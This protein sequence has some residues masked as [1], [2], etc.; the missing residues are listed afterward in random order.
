VVMVIISVI[1]LIIVA[2]LVST[3]RGSNKTANLNEVRENGNGA[4]TRMAEAISFAKSFEGLTNTPDTNSIP[5]VPTSDIYTCPAPKDTPDHFT[6]LYLKDFSDN[7][8]V[9]SCVNSDS[10]GSTS[11]LWN[12]T[13]LIDTHS[14]SID[15]SDPN[16]CYFTCSQ[17]YSTQ[18]P[19]IGI[20]FSLTKLSGSSLFEQQTAPVI[21]HTDAVMRN[22]GK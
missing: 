16:S 15:P 22:L 11:L 13:D 10:G 21:F 14:I 18:P 8:V 9:L 3:T 20:Y 6:S 12:G 4:I 17:E 1:G 7:V 2:I 5:T 19:T